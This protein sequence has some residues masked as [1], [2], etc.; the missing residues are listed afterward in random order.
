[1]IRMIRLST[2]KF[3]VYSGFSVRDRKTV[4]PL[5][6]MREGLSVYAAVLVNR[7]EKRRRSL[8]SVV[9]F[10]LPCPLPYRFRS[11]DLF[12][13]TLPTYLNWM[14]AGS[15]AGARVGP[16]SA[17]PII[18]NVASSMSPPIATATPAI[19]S[20]IPIAVN[21]IISVSPKH[22]SGQPDAVHLRFL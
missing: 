8:V 7:V 1:M 21:S 9:G 22:S 19:I 12:P 13:V 14:A 4:L 3:M 15:N 20:P 18:K 6:S 2:L 16:R 11:S 17:R 5:R 10:F